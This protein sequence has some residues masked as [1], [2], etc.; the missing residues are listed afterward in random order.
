[1]YGPPSRISTLRLLLATL[2]AP[3]SPAFADLWAI[4]T[5]FSYSRVIRMDN[6]GVEKVGAGIPS[7][8]RA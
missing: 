3:A 2:F 8:A 1:M 6:D 7:G 5:D 4:S